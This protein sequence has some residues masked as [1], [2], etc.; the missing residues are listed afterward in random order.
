M[1]IKMTVEGIGIDPQNNTLVLLRDE[2]HKVFVPI[3]I[4]PAEAMSIQ[5]ELDNRQPPRPMTHDLM[6]DVLRKLDVQLLKV[7]VNDV[8]KLV[9][10]ATLHIQ[11]KDEGSPQ[12]IDARPSDAIALALRAQCGIWVSDQVIDKSGIQVEEVSTEAGELPSL[13][14]E[15]EQPITEVSPDEMDRFSK[16]LEGVDLS[17]KSGESQAN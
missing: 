1:M 5:M 14:L 9:Y 10:Y 7:T 16:L 3:Y 6:A 4:G 8:D 17:G 2:E 12:E 13:T 11:G 15:D